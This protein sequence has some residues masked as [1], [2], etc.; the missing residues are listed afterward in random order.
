MTDSGTVLDRFKNTSLSFTDDIEALLR[1]ISSCAI[2][3]K[4]SPPEDCL[5]QVLCSWQAT[6]EFL[7][8]CFLLGTRCIDLADKI[9]NFLPQLTMTN[10]IRPHTSTHQDPI[11]TAFKDVRSMCAELEQAVQTVR[12]LN[13]AVSD[14]ERD[15]L[16][17]V[18]QESADDMI[19]TSFEA[20]V[21]ELDQYWHSMN[22]S[23]LAGDPTINAIIT[24]YQEHIIHV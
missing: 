17:V 1:N 16:S 11:H 12:E 8:T 4:P 5:P 14:T 21:L 15:G 18:L 23:A 22:L 19:S 20:H 2:H 3:R 13:T 10:D 6:D 24:M 7:K 9:M